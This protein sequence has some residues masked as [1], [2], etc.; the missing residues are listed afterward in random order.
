MF[1][2]VRISFVSYSYKSAAY[3]KDKNKSNQKVKVK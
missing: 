3:R 2:E 1:K